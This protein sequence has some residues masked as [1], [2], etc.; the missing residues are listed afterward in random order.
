[1]NAQVWYHEKI[2][3]QLYAFK[4][5]IINLQLGRL[6]EWFEYFAA[7]IRTHEGT[8]PP[9]LGPYVN[10]VRRVPLGVCG[11]LTPWNHPMLIAIKKIAPAIATGNSVVVLVPIIM[12][13]IKYLCKYESQGTQKLDLSSSI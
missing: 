1:M 5:T 10:Y 12:D 11:L 9:F 7:V 4:E 8:V 13:Y 6:P 3:N 2:T